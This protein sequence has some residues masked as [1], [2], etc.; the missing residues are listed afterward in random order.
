V[1]SPYAEAVLEDG[2]SSF[3]RLSDP[4]GSTTAEDWVGTATGVAGSG[5][6]WGATGAIDGDADTAADFSGTSAGSVATQTAIAGP[7]T[8]TIESWFRTTTRAGG[9]IVGF[10]NRSTGSSTSYDRHVYLDTSGR[11]LFGVYPGAERTLQSAAGMNDG[12]WH[13]VVAT[14]GADGM[15][16]YVDGVRVGQ[17]TDTTSA[18]AYSGYWRIGGDKGWAG[19]TWF[20][21]EIDDVAIY[22]APLSAAQVDAHWVAAG[23]A[24]AV[25]PAPEDA[26]GAAV[27]GLDPD[28]FWRL[29]D[30]TGA[31]A[32]DS[33]P[34]LAPGVYVGTVGRGVAGAL[35]GQPD[36][37]AV[38]LSGTAGSFVRSS[39]QYVNPTTYSQE[40]WFSTTTELGG[41]LIGFGN[42]ATGTS[43]DYDR[44]VYMET[45]GRLTFGVWTGQA[46]TITSSAAYNDGEWHHLVASQSAEGMR[47]FVDGVLVGTHP[48]TAAQAYTGYWRV[49]G[50]ITWG[51]QPWFAGRIDEVAVYSTGLTAGQVA[52]HYQLGSGNVPNQAP[53][54]T[55]TT[56]VEDLTVQVDGA[57][58]GDPDG[59]VE[60]YAWDFDGEATA[61]GPQASH[62]FATAGD[63]PVTLTVTDDDGA[64]HSTTQVVTVRAPNQEPTAAFTVT[65]TDLTVGLDASSSTD[66][67]GT[68]TGW[69]WDF[70]DGSAPATGQTATHAYGAGGEYTV[71]LTVTDDR[72]GEA[73]TSQGVTVQAPVG[74]VVLAADTF[75]RS[76]TSTWGTPDAGGGWAHA[77]SASLFTV[78][79]GVG[80]LTLATGGSSP[81]ARL[82][83]LSATDVDATVSFTVDKLSNA[84]ATRVW[85]TGRQTA[86]TSEYLVK[87]NIAQSGN[88][89]GLQLLRKVGG[90]EVAVAQVAPGVTVAPGTRYT[91]RLQVV[92]SGTTTL[93]AK[94]WA[95]EAT[96]PGWQVE[97]TDSTPEL[98]TP[99]SVGVGAYVAGSTG[100]LP[101][102]VAWDDLRVTTIG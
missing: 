23:G 10:G 91:L 24:S 6:G 74:P 58:S 41:K 89:S 49:G 44:H 29:D 96:E 68:V 18:Q 1:L 9:K 99:G 75:E 73:T 30:A 42:G 60:G 101:V 11:V 26:Y 59:E 94:L 53:V 66:P 37:R 79:D 14:L 47:L 13:H 5:V 32:A 62:T 85:L 28:L 50:D 57:A 2:A 52:Q 22:P 40:L 17:R 93:R 3:W 54:A 77:G 67:D 31:T 81:R 72:G 27:H 19:A 87:A 70:G 45:D 78:G 92:G 100:N 51:P 33:G 84:G 90:T 61:T 4:A 43:T 86:W 39:D 38:Q 36:N 76:S 64:T 48:Q 102:V 80:R 56:T 82:G 97:V 98:Q 71:T 20:D 63:R 35:D 65:A 7:Q 95:A 69:T 25:P 8:F 34:M 55:F 83:A 15:K 16:L 46:S 21:G 12:E 88:V